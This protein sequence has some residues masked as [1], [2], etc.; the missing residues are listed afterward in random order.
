MQS[1]NYER[2]QQIVISDKYNAVK[3]DFNEDLAALAKRYFEVDGIKS[4]AYF[5]DTLKITVTLSVKKV[6]QIR[7]VLA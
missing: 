1:K 5:D 3:T 7:R 2:A 4:E 6:K